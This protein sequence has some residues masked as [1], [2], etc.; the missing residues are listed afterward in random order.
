MLP[1]IESSPSDKIVVKEGLECIKKRMADL[2]EAV[3]DAK[4]RAD[5]EAQERAELEI[6]AIKESLLSQHRPS[7][8]GLK[9]RP[10][11]SDKQSRRVRKAI[12]EAIEAL[13]APIKKHLVE[14]IVL[15]DGCARYIGDKS[16]TT[17]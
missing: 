17:K 16:W 3:Q 10:I 1:T 8:G 13:A 15:Q 12:Q 11:E 14:K 2:E 9:V 6:E 7:G 4:Q 5:S